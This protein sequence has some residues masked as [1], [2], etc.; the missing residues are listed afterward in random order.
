MRIKYI[1]IIITSYILI[2]CGTNKNLI[3]QKEKIKL[4]TFTYFTTNKKKKLKLDFYK[5]PTIK[6]N[7]P[8]LI[9]V[10]GGGFSGGA[11]NEDY[12]KN[13][14]IKMAREGF[15]V[16]S[17]SYRLTMKKYGFGCS[18][19]SSLKI[20]AFNKASEDISLATQYLLENKKKLG[21][22]DSKVILIGSS[23]G[24]E[25]VLNLAYVYDN[26]ILPQNFKYA[27]IIAMAG[28]ITSLDKLDNKTI[29]P[30]QLFHGV[31]D[32]LVPYGKAPHHYCKKD[33]EGY[34]ELYGSKAIADKLKELNGSYY[35][36]TIEDGDHSWNSKP[37]FLNI[38][39]ILTFIDEQVINQQKKQ[40]E[41]IKKESDYNQNQL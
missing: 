13:F 33:D 37:M 25:A 18:T 7:T 17:I 8:L 26:K 12:I 31:K 1:V 4:T 27:G 38:K 40:V 16:A 3:Q 14:C 32:S 29:I 10:H 20:N 22:D 30:T 23:A 41:I 6:G 2:G 35:L 36:Q 5:S 28:A 15:A 11:R 21:L 19:P 39:E 24:A 34:L 9:Y